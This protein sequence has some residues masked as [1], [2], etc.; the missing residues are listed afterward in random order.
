MSLITKGS[1]SG[2]T[3]SLGGTTYGTAS[4][5]S[6]LSVGA[7]DGI[8]FQP[9]KVDGSGNLLVALTGAGSGGTSAA[10]L[11][12]WVAGT[13]AGTPLMGARDDAASGVVA[14]DKLGVARITTNRALHINLRKNDA[15]ELGV[16]GAALIVD[17]SAVTQPISAASLPLPTGASTEA[18]LALI[19][20]KTDNL[21]VALSTRTKP[22]DTQ[23]ISGSVTANIGTSGSLAL[24]ATVATPTTLFDGKKTVTTAGTRVTL[25]ASQAVKSVTIKALTT[26]TGTIYVGD[27][28]VSSA[29][30]LQL[31]AGDSISF[32]IANLN[33]VNLDSS[34][35]GEGVTYLGVN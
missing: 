3:V 6:G 26:N 29:N 14:E 32:D 34:V 8:N 28:S 23:T 24:D 13:T 18:T 35:N 20:A 7:T 5:T 21:D 11:A 12:A 17:N 33:T 9:L 15:T 10:D 16:A 2:L 31:A 30:G 25:A 19:K 4:P 22:A 1:V 27:T